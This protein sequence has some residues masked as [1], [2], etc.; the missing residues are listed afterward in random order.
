M[1]RGGV[2]V[3]RLP[4]SSPNLNGYADRF[5]LSIRRECLDR[6]VPLGEAHLRQRSAHPPRCRRSSTTGGSRSRPARSATVG[7]ACDRGGLEPDN[8]AL[9]VIV[10]TRFGV[11]PSTK[12]QATVIGNRQLWKMNMTTA[13]GV[14][15]VIES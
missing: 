12:V 7:C 11:I 15:L 5:V 13:D 14:R 1:K 2:E 3:L 8:A 10:R 9:P 6:I 4:P